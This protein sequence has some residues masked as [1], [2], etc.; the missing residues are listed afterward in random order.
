MGETL[1]DGET[2]FFGFEHLRDGFARCIVVDNMF[3]NF[4]NIRVPLNQSKDAKK[5]TR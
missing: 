2:H 5:K 1:V 4:L 3:I